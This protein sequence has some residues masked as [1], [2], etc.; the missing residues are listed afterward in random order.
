M[1]IAATFT[2][3]GTLLLTA[4]PSPQPSPTR[5]VTNLTEFHSEADRPYII[6]ALANEGNTISIEAFQLGRMDYV[7]DINVILGGRETP[8]IELHDRAKYWPL[9]ILTALSSDITLGGSISF[10]GGGK[11]SAPFTVGI[12]PDYPEY[13]GLVF[14]LQIT[15]KPVL[16]SMG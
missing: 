5:V 1:S 7:V 4:N 14:K 8:L 3:L 13:W 12:I 16:T 6:L 10:T 15:E 11:W 9:A 2:A